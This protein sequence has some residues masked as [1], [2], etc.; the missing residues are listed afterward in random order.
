MNNENNYNEDESFEL[1]LQISKALH[2]A[3]MTTSQNVNDASSSS[4]DIIS[5][6]NE[7][8][9]RSV[10]EDEIRHARQKTKQKAQ[11]SYDDMICIQNMKIADGE[12]IPYCIARLRF[13]D[14]TDIELPFV[15][16][17]TLQ[18]LYDILC[19][20]YGGGYRD[21][22]ICSRINGNIR[23]RNNPILR[24]TFGD[25]RWKGRHIWHVYQET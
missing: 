23:L 11:Q 20:R 4:S 6:Q 10:R 15:K 17:D 13:E 3:M 22:R 2:D 9:K 7:E 1:A 5:K 12:S 16:D 19:Q 24:N 8:Y 18:L 14:N 21:I 25:Q